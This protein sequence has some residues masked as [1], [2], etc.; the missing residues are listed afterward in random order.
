MA[1]SIVVLAS[2][3]ALR[4]TAGGPLHVVLTPDGAEERGARALLLKLA[5]SHDLT[6]YLFTREVRIARGA[7]AHS[8]PVL[9][10]SLDGDDDPDEFLSAFLHEEIHWF[11]AARSSGSEKAEAEFRKM[12]PRLPADPDEV[13]DDEAA[14]YRHLGVCWLELQADK[15]YL[16]SERAYALFRKADGY[17]WIY[18]TVVDDEERIGAVLREHGLVIEP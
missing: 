10:L 7:R 15:K 3:L 6:P 14:T 13:A 11:W 16:G 8:L 17:K 18:R 1:R 4:V 2:V 12:Y 5:R 9:T